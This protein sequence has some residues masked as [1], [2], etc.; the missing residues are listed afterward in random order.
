M[1]RYVLEEDVLER[2]QGKVR[3]TDDPEE[4]PGLL[5][6]KL[7]IR[8]ID[9]AEA[10]LEYDLAERYSAPFETTDCKSF[11]HLPAS[12][13]QRAIRRLAAIKAVI[14]VLDTDFGRGTIVDASKY[15]EE[16]EKQYDG[17]VSK[18]LER[19]RDQESWRGPPLPGLRLAAHNEVGDDG[20]HGTIYVTSDSNGDFAARQVN[21][22]AESLYWSWLI[23]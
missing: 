3:V 19:R 16:C 13:T 20:F 22:P 5:S 10:E 14:F 17:F 18:L 4:E 7:L 6:R 11:S 9:E 21:E 15:K 12:P 8:L 23:R 2:L 1:P